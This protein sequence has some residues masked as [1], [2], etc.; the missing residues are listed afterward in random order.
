MTLADMARFLR[1]HG[2]PAE[3]ASTG[4]NCQQVIIYLTGGG[5]VLVGDESGPLGDIDETVDAWVILHY[6]SDEDDP[7][8]IGGVIP[9]GAAAF[10][11]VLDKLNENF[12]GCFNE[13][14]GARIH[15]FY[16]H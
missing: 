15:S 14:M 9:A 11:M 10:D 1:S 13:P 8:E 7:I 12:E 6:P 16:D 4:G 3:A 5:E 2:L